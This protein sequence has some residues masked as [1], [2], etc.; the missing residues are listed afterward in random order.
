MAGSIYKRLQPIGCPKAS[1]YVSWKGG[2]DTKNFSSAEAID[3]LPRWDKILSYELYYRSWLLV[4]WSLG[5]P[6]PACPRSRC[7][8]KVWVKYRVKGLKFLYIELPMIKG[9]TSSPCRV[10]ISRS[11]HKIRST[12]ACNELGINPRITIVVVGKRHH[13]QCVCEFLF[14]RSAV[15]MRSHY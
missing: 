12:D 14:C 15:L 1:P 13:N 2:K 3:I 6:I 5:G 10:A 11:W 8:L 4:R 9:I 7:I